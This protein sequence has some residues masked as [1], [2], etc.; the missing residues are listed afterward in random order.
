[1]KKTSNTW[2]ISAQVNTVF[3]HVKDLKKAARW[4]SDLFGLDINLE[5]VHSP[6]YNIPVNGDTSITLDDHSFDPSFQHS[7]S[8]NPSFNFYTSNIEEAY[9]FVK[10]KGIRITREIERVDDNTIWFNIADIDGN[11]IM[12]CNC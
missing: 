7:P 2:P 10:E 12:I 8:N 9:S 6:V 1:M 11:H 5:N 4:Y 3:I